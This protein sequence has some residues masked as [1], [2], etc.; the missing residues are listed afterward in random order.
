M[1]DDQPPSDGGEPSG[2]TPERW[3]K[4]ETILGEQEVAQMLADLPP[5]EAEA[6]LAELEE[7]YGSSYDYD[8][9]D[10]YGA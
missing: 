7:V 4:I 5:N 10:D 1:G 3:H 8:D 2:I 9:Y 6:V